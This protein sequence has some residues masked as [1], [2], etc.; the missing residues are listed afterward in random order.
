MPCVSCI[1]WTYHAIHKASLECTAAYA[2]EG[3][4]SRQ[5]DILRYS[6]FST[7]EERTNS[8]SCPTINTRV[9]RMVR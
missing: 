6:S 3:T 7:N 8:Y 2:P 1:I 5:D 4:L 9:R